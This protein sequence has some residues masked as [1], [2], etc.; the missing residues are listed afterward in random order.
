MIRIYSKSLDLS[1]FFLLFVFSVGFLE[2]HGR[3]EAP[4]TIKKPV[5]GSH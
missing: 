1:V 4:A 5:P 3:R 2:V